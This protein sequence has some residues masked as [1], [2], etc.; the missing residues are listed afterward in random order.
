MK[1][2]IELPDESPEPAP[3]HEE[4]WRRV[5]GKAKPEEIVEIDAALTESFEEIDLL[6][7]R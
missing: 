1:A 7:W 4:A 6:S 2:T 5:L 3:G